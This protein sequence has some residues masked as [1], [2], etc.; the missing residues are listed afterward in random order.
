MWIGSI[1]LIL[2]T[3]SYFINLSFC[4]DRYY[5]S[6]SPHYDNFR[7]FMHC[8]YKTLELNF[9]SIKIKLINE[10]Q[11][12]VSKLICNIGGCCNQ[13]WQTGNGPQPPTTIGTIPQV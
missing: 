7:L 2:A 4:V 8:G 11:L 10:F 1:L 6:I 5:A 3:I 12:K 13:C 9:I